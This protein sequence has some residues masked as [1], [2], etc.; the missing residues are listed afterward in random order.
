MSAPVNFYCWTLE[1]KLFTINYEQWFIIYFREW[2]YTCIDLLEEYKK[3][4]P[5]D[6]SYRLTR[7]DVYRELWDTFWVDEVI[8]APNPTTTDEDRTKY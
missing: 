7:I 3:F 4:Y 6:E 1:C 8:I 5:D 2:H